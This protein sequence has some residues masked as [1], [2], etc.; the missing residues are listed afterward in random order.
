MSKLISLILH[1]IYS[2]NKWI[3]CFR[4]VKMFFRSNNMCSIK[5]ILRKN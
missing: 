5:R 2:S 1:K 3:L 4:G